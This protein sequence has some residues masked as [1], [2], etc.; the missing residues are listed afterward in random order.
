MA[1]IKSQIT[2]VPKN[3]KKPSQVLMAHALIPTTWEVEIGRIAV[4]S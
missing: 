3:V 2:S 1:R 4:R